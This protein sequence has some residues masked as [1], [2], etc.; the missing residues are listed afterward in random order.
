MLGSLLLGSVMWFD[1]DGADGARDGTLSVV[2]STFTE[3]TLTSSEAS[4]VMAGAVSVEV[5]QRE[6]SGEFSADLPQPAEL[7]AAESLVSLVDILGSAGYRG[8]IHVE[9]T[10][11]ILYRGGVPGVGVEMS[12]V[13]SPVTA[14]CPEN[15]ARQQAAWNGNTNAAENLPAS[16]RGIVW[17]GDS[18]AY[19]LAAGP[20]PREWV[21]IQFDEECFVANFDHRSTATVL[22]V[23]AMMGVADD[24]SRALR[25][26]GLT[27]VEQHLS[28][29]RFAEADP[30]GASVFWTMFST[31]CA[32]RAE[33]TAC[34]RL[35]LETSE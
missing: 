7:I 12:F 4:S 34:A 13:A 35:L 20:E 24:H 15:M 29:S 22:G 8:D 17:L 1:G 25:A 14:G 31:R 19:G 32:V 6:F 11:F 10:S 23:E 33:P 27:T 30:G 21:V 5:V 16:E 2:G 3:V 18:T 26:L 28:A 9:P